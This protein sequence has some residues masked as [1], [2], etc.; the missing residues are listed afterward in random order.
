MDIFPSPQP[1]SLIK[2][3]ALPLTC[4]VTLSRSPSLSE[5]R[6]LICQ[7]QIMNICPTGLTQMGDWM[8]KSAKNGGHPKCEECWR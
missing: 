3:P 8:R 7:A 6:I 4:C 1:I 5:P 2:V